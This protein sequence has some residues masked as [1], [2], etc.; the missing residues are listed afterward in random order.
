MAFGRRRPEWA[1]RPRLSTSSLQLLRRNRDASGH[2]GMKRAEILVGAGLVEHPAEGLA[3]RERFG[4]G[5]A[6]PER[7][8]MG[9]TVVVAPGNRIAGLDG[10]GLRPEREAG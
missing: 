5:R 1:R 10:G 4:A 6:V 7:D 3:G 2:V 8:R 9:R